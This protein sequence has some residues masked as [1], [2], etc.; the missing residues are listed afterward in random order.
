M[1]TSTAALQRLSDLQILWYFSQ[2]KINLDQYR[3][4]RLEGLS[5]VSSE[6]GI[7]V[8]YEPEFDSRCSIFLF[9]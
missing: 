3:T 1:R 9:Y 5:A 2:T 7:F 6:M 8:G 4:K